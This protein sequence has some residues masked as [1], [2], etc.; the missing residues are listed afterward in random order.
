MAQLKT[1]LNGVTLPAT[2]PVTAASA[3]K[4]LNDALDNIVQ[5]QNVG[6]FIGRNLI[7]HLVTSNPSPAYIARVT[8]AFNDNGS[9]VRGD[10]KAVIRAIL[11]DPEALNPSPDS[12]FGHLLEPILFKTRLLRAFDT[13]A[14]TTDFAL[15]D[16]YLPSE[17]G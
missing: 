2:S 1:L 7:E 4:D 5:H 17:L 12:L 14:A 6:P 11:L 3:T 13:M 15:T 16:T 9:G 10:L 8:A